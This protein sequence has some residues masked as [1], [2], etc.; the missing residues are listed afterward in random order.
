MQSYF[1]S[2]SYATLRGNLASI[3][4]SVLATSHDN[5]L[6]VVIERVKNFK[7][8]SGK[9]HLDCVAIDKKHE[10]APIVNS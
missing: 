5:A 4:R 6:S 2:G 3:R 8:Y 7:N 9:I 1:V 10:S